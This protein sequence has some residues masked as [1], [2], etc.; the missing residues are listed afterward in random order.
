[1]TAEAP[2]A[3]AQRQR[4][5]DHAAGVWSASSRYAVVLLLLLGIFAYFSMTQPDFL[6]QANIENLLT[7]SSILF[8]V[9][10]G[11]TFV[12]LTGGIDL[13]VGSLLRCRESCSRRS[14]TTG[15][16]PHRLPCCSPA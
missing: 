5:I 3:D 9:S 13:S 16:W 11:M 4:V 14:S 7:S 8:V 10:I 12:V 1:M 15:G 2:V 6:S